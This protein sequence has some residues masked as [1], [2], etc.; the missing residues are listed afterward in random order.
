M[1]KKRKISQNTQIYPNFSLKI[2]I[3]HQMTKEIEIKQII[4]NKKK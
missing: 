4:E 2:T 3:L 1:N